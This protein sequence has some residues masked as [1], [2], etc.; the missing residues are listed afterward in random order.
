M[1]LTLTDARVSLWGT[2]GCCS[3]SDA[4][5]LHVLPRTPGLTHVNFSS[6]KLITDRTVACL[7]D[8]IQLNFLWYTVPCCALS[9]YSVVSHSVRCV[10]CVLLS[11]WIRAL[12]ATAVCAV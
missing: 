5:M 2:S 4:L 3:L 6:C 7:A 1:K 12:S 11:V 8:K 10:L 9:V